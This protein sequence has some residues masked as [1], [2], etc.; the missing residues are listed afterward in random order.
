MQLRMPQPGEVWSHY[1]AGARYE[2]VTLAYDEET[3]QPLVIYRRVGSDGRVWA[4]PLSKFLSMPPDSHE[5]RFTYAWGPGE[6]SK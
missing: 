5:A 1:K 6:V 2:I 4:R 3:G